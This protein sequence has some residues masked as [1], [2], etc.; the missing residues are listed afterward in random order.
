LRTKDNIISP[1]ARPR[2]PGAHLRFRT[3]T[4][5]IE[6]HPAKAPGTTNGYAVEL[7]RGENMGSG[8]EAVLGQESNL[9]TAL[10]L[11]NLMV[12]HYPGRLIMLCDGARVLARS[13]RLDTMAG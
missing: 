8:I 4:H 13:D 5:S 3:T 11:Y 6:R 10:V 1:A 9:K 2:V 7:F 12:A